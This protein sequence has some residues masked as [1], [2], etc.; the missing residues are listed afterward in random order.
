M[1]QPPPKIDRYAGLHISGPNSLKSVVIVLEGALPIKPLNIAGLYEKIGSQGKLFSD[2]RLV[3]IL[4]LRGPFQEVFVDCPLS[5]PPCVSCERPVCPGAINCE[6]VS[7]A[8]MLALNEKI[9][10]LGV[11]K[12]RP[13]NP[14]SQRLWDIIYQSEVGSLP[15]SDCP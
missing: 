14:Q 8:Y 12:K 6:D 3:D 15:H 11:R 9:K 1:L 4:Q 5:V 2:D 7:V 13:I 10:S